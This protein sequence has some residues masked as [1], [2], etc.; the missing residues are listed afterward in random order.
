MKPA[1]NN[2]IAAKEYNMNFTNE[3]VEKV[4]S[5]TEEGRF[6][7]DGHSFFAIKKGQAFYIYDINAS[8]QTL[9]P[10]CVLAD[11]KLFLLW[12]SPQI[13][14]RFSENIVL[15]REETRKLEKEFTNQLAKEFPVPELPPDT[16]DF[17]KFK[18]KDEKYFGKFF[19]PRLM[20]VESEDFFRFLQQDISKEEL[21][22]KTKKD[23]HPHQRNNLITEAT[24]R[25]EIDKLLSSGEDLISEEDLQLLQTIRETCATR[26]S[27]Q[28][29]TMQTLTIRAEDIFR[30]LMLNKE[31][32]SIW[33]TK[34]RKSF[35]LN[36]LASISYH[37]QIIYEKQDQTQTQAQTIQHI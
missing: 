13:L 30:A 15:I 25:K 31:T 26:L 22:T 20:H 27:A 8:M 21:Y 29:E 2:V 5:I 12:A 19:E 24:I 18:A 36:D 6:D 33:D 7:A 10:T 32:T 1:Q 9:S 17:L 11:K 3:F 4:L 28:T 23:L 34:S 37:G 35:R 14:S 16:Q